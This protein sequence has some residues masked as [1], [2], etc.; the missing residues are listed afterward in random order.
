MRE[1]NNIT[2][3]NKKWVGS[4]EVNYTNRKVQWLNQSD[5]MINGP[6]AICWEASS[7]EVQNSVFD[8]VVLSIFISNLHQ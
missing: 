4:K 8:C 7:D 2:Y 6:K 5:V 1:S 3:L